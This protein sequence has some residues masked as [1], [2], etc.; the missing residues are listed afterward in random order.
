[1]TN[2][3]LEAV[4]HAIVVVCARARTGLELSIRV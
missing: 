1:M 4:H 2:D 3:L